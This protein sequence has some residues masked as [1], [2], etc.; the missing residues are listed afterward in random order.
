MATKKTS[1]EPSYTSLAL[2]RVDETNWTLIRHTHTDDGT[3]LSREMDD[4]VPYH[5]VVYAMKREA[6]RLYTKDL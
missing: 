4:P 5:L 1:S 3:V 2:R 6:S